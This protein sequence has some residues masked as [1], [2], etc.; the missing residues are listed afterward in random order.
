LD[1][2]DDYLNGDNEY[3]RGMT[4]EQN[5]A[6]FAA[7]YPMTPEDSFMASTKSIVAGSIIKKQRDRILK[8]CHPYEALKPKK[9]KFLS[10]LQLCEQDAS[11]FLAT[12]RNSGC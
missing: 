9:G 2:Y 5:R 3:T 10:G 11:R 4:P 1:Q 8:E 6:I 12:L 7:H